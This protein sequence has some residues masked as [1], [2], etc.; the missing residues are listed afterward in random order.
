MAIEIETINP[1]AQYQ[2]TLTA[3][4]VVGAEAVLYPGQDIVLRGDLV[5]EHAAAIDHAQAV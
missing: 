1:E 4:I 3:K 2:V 5:L